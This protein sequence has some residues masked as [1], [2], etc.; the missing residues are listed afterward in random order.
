MLYFPHDRLR[1]IQSDLV[2]KVSK[3]IRERRNLLINAPTG[4][5]KTAAVLAPAFSHSYESDKTVFFLTSKHTQ[6][7]I[8]VETMKRIKE[9]FN[10]NFSAVN[11][12]GKRW[13]CCQPNIS[14]LSS[15]DFAEFCKALREDSAC[16]YYSN[17]V[18]GSKLTSS[19]SKI[20]SEVKNEILHS[21]EITKKCAD[22]EICPYYLAN[23]VANE[24]KVVVTDYYYLLNPDIRETFFSRSRK[25]LGKSIIIIDEAHNLPLRAR[26]LLSQKLTTS[27]I[28]RAVKEAKRFRYEECLAC[29]ADLQN[30]VLELAKGMDDFSEK[31]LVKQDLIEKFSGIENYDSAISVLMEAAIEVREKQ[32]VSYLGSVASFL[33]SWKGGD[34]G[35]VRYVKAEPRK[36]TI[37]YNC[38]DPSIIT[39]DLFSQAYCSIL[40]SATLQ[41]LEMY[42]D[43]LCI[44]AEL[45]SFESPFEAKNRLNLIVPLTTTKFES[46]SETQYQNIAKI[47]SD[48]SNEVEGN[49]LIFFPSYKI[50]DDVEKYFSVQ[51]KKTVFLEQQLMT[52]EEKIRML[53]KYKEYK[54]VGAVLLAVV[55]GNFAEGIDLPGVI[56][57][58]IIVG[59][60]LQNPD[61]ETKELINYYDKKFSKGWEYGYVLPAFTKTFQ[62]AGRCIRSEKD[63]GVIVYLDKRY[64]WS[65]YVKNFPG[66]W[67]IKQTI[68]YLPAI[69]DFF[70]GNK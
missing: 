43:L 29:L 4:L 38:L 50:R 55:S 17:L 33:E 62:A 23:A 28:V 1:K 44:D 47:I 58:I 3:A 35:F 21:E 9:K 2:N 70:M 32:K 27:T 52:K 37:F 14:V 56:K 53:E 45:L 66:E 24:S 26:E 5:G 15:R 57:C 60:P 51:S 10:L 19:G 48:I 63:K 34:E 67:E 69:K 39:K 20:F 59:L 16:Q 6:H 31:K 25:E 36:L 65:N 22:A 12:I 46:R 8:A 54:D 41:P 68:N 49:T 40:M 42:R 7:K 61:I 30:A 13:M 64:V 18:K 11:I